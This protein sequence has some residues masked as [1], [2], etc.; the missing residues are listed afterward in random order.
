[1]KSTSAEE[2]PRCSLK[3]VLNITLRQTT[4]NID[5]TTWSLSLQFC[6]Q[7]SK[8][9]TSLMPIPLGIKKVEEV[10]TL[11]YVHTH[12]LKDLLIVKLYKKQKKENV[13][14]ATTK[15][16]LQR[17]LFSGFEGTCEFIGED[18]YG[19]L[20]LGSVMFQ[21]ESLPQEYSSSEDVIRFARD[22]VDPEIIEHIE[23][24]DKQPEKKS[25]TNVLRRVI[26]LPKKDFPKSKKCLCRVISPY[27]EEATE[28]DGFDDCQCDLSEIKNGVLVVF[29]E[30]KKKA[31][32]IKT[33]LSD[34]DS[35]TKFYFY[36]VQNG[37]FTTKLLPYLSNNTNLGIT[38][39]IVLCGGDFFFGMFVRQLLEMNAKEKMVDVTPFIVPTTRNCL[40]AKDLGEIDVK[41]KNMFC[42]D[43]LTKI[44]NEKSKARDALLDYFN[45]NTQQKL[46]L[47]E[48]TITDNEKTFN[49]HM[50]MSAR[51]L[52]EN[53]NVSVDYWKVKDKKP[54]TVKTKKLIDMFELVKVRKDDCF[55]VTFSKPEKKEDD[56]NEVVM[57][58]KIVI[59]SE[60][61][62]IKVMVDRCLVS[63]EASYITFKYEMPNNV[64]FAVQSFN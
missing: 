16:S 15:V 61:E 63:S 55:A 20:H 36:E 28:Y 5:D 58:T 47:S 35:P 12:L 17:I 10:I 6:T 21:V 34:S 7:Q 52:C 23:T 37:N 48:I 51:V 45:Q 31:E 44:D 33:L 50:L 46:K 9:K 19:D 4:I 14:I 43:F 42:T 29:Q 13:V 11:P 8:N 24:E 26:H 25:R 3:R 64:F 56:V 62:G 22:C 57:C 39:P 38:V 18:K 49:A 59:S 30:K 32:Q 53:K 54:T 27:E 2:L 60:D 1:M 41:Y 40:V